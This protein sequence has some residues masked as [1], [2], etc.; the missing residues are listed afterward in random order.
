MNITTF[1]PLTKAYHPV[2]FIK[3]LCRYSVHKVIR[4]ELFQ[5]E[6]LDSMECFDRCVTGETS[7][8]IISFQSIHIKSY[9]YMDI[10]IAKTIFI[11]L[12]P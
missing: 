3:S 1:I 8:E 5:D 6:P 10:Q 9:L 2:K 12:N 4:K 7:L 11:T